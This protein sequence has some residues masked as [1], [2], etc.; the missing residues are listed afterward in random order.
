MSGGLSKR[1]KGVSSNR[2]EFATF[3]PGLRAKLTAV[4][5]DNSSFVSRGGGAEEG[6]EGEGG[7]VL[8]EF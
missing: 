7:W 1:G 2:S 4:V 8:N 6:D 5:E 3:L